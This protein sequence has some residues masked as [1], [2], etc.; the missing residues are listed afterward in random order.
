MERNSAAGVARLVAASMIGGLRAG[1]WSYKKARIIEKKKC[2]RAHAAPQGTCDNLINALKLLTNRRKMAT[3]QLGKLLQILDGLRKFI[4]VDNHEA[5][6]VGDL[7][8]ETGSKNVVKPKFTADF[9]GAVIHEG[10]GE[11]T[12]RAHEEGVLRTFIDTPN[13]GDRGLGPPLA[14]AER[15]A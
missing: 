13:V 6:T 8:L 12:L 14:D 5:V 4:A 7:H 15:H 2:C 1:S 10:A 11:L 3:V 9:P